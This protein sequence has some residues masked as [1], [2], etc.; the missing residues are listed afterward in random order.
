MAD[1]RLRRL[2]YDDMDAV[3]LIH[4]RAFDTQLPWLAGLHTP[5][6]D[7]EFYRNR[8][9]RECVLWGAEIG[10]LLA[11]FVAFREEWI[12]QFYILPALQRQGVG[13]ALLQ[14]AQDAWPMLQ[15]YTFQ[16]NTGA[17]RFYEAHGFVGISESDGQDNE[18]CE[19]DVLYC[20]A[21]SY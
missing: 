20:W 12:D 4:R 19:P 7:R 2:A 3:A 15:L 6:E 13:S 21:R 11:G 9:F 5:F 17:R 16:R 18:E 8:V 10:G 1:M 14:V